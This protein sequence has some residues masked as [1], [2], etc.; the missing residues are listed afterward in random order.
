MATVPT[1]NAPAAATNPILSEPRVKRII[2]LEDPS[3]RQPQ[4]F[5]INTAQPLFSF[6]FFRFASCGCT[7][8]RWGWAC[9]PPK[10]QAGLTIEN[11]GVD[12]RVHRVTPQEDLLRRG[13]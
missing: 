7:A 13:E 6:H 8:R 3:I 9:P 12:N 1:I 5:G 11:H 2:L 10:R 4:P